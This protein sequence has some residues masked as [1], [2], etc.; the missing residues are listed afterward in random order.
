MF[1]GGMTIENAGFDNFGFASKS[2]LSIQRT[3]HFGST[4]LGSYV[5]GSSGIAIDHPKSRRV[6]KLKVGAT[7]ASPATDH[8]VL[9]AYC[10]NDHFSLA[11][12]RLPC[13]RR[14]R[15][16]HRWPNRSQSVV[17]FASQREN[18]LSW[19]YSACPLRRKKREH[20]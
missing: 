13:H 12:E 5:F 11:H 10:R 2:R 17:R 9:A 18:F 19:R 8:N 14:I 6:C 16:R 1:G 3:Y 15:F 4:V 20:G 7:A